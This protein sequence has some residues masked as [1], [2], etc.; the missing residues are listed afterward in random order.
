MPARLFSFMGVD[1]GRWRHEPFDFLTWFEY[2][3]A[4][5]A[6]FNKL[7]AA[8]RATAEWAYVER[9]IDIRLVRETDAM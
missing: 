9:A 8:L 7:L 2:E 1:T 4:H 6:A 3:P 5:E